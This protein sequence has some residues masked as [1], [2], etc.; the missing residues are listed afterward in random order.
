LKWRL[1]RPLI[2]CGQRSLEVFCVGLLLSFVGHFLLE[3]T[4]ESPFAQLLVSL[5][6]IG[7]MTGVAYYRSWAKKLDKR[8]GLSA[9]AAPRRSSTRDERAELMPEAHG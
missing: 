5:T 3:L 2:V 6:G 4:A 9:P 7:V 1:L 8:P